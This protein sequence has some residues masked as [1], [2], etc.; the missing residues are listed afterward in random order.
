MLIRFEKAIYNI[1]ETFCRD[2]LPSVADLIP[3]DYAGLQNLSTTKNRLTLFY[4]EDTL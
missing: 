3:T 1:H 4:I 2:F